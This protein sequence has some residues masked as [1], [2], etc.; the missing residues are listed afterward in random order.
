MLIIG[1]FASMAGA[2][3]AFLLALKF[4]NDKYYSHFVL[5][6]CILFFVLISIPAINLN[7]KHNNNIFIQIAFDFCAGLFTTLPIFLAKK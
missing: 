7:I 6:S 5:S 2:L 4:I 1:A 3:L